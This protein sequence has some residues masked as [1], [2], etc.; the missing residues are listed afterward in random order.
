MCSN[1]EASLSWVLLAART[2]PYPIPGFADPF[3]SLSH[4]LGAGVFACLTPFLLW[5]G[6]G[7]AGRLFFLGVFAFA[8]VLLLS[9]SGVYHLLST[10]GV[11]RAVLKRLDH[12][13]IFILIAGT[14]TPVHG[15]LFRGAWRWGPLLFIW[16]GAA[17]G[18]T[19]KT[20]FFDDVAEWLGLTFYLSLGWVGVISGL[21]CWRRYGLAFI[22]PLIWGGLAYTVGGVLEFL[23]WPVLIPGVVGSHELFHV[24][25]L[26]GIAFH[27]KFV[28][29]FASG[30]VVESKKEG[31]NCS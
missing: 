25:V 1:S 3:S 14:F 30:E 18:V 27:W 17:A 19:L 15:I 10:G 7:N 2:A 12:G 21:E 28:F 24:G 4:L 6:R 20:I 16:L 29:Q 23:R 31:L 22:K 9:M 26:A 8:T 13:A 5:R 11:A